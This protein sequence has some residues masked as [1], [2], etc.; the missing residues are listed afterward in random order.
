MKKVIIIGAGMGGLVAGN[1]L[2]KDGHAV[3]IFEAHRLPGGYTAGFYRDGFYFESG[4]LSFEAG[5]SVFKAMRDI[6]VYD[7]LEFVRK[8]HRWVT[9]DFDGVP[10]SYADLKQMLYTAYPTEKD[11]LDAFFA[12][13][14]KM[15]VVTKMDK[16]MPYLYHGLP[17]LLAMLSY[18]P[19]A[20]RAAGLLKKYEHMTTS[21]FAAQFFARGSKLYRLFTAPAYPDMTAYLLGGFLAGVFHDYWTVKGGMQSWAD[22]LAESF[23]RYGGT[24]KLGAPVDKIITRDGAAAG[25]A[26][27]GQEYTADTVI[28]ACDYKKTLLQMLDDK[29]LVPAALREKIVQAAVSEGVFTVYLGLDM[30]NAALRENMVLPDVLYLNANPDYDIYDANDA[31]F[32]RKTPLT[33]YSPS[34]VNPGHAPEGK[35]SL[36][37]QTFV[38]SKWMGN[39]G[40]GDRTV[41]E[42]LKETARE[43]MIAQAAAIIPGVADKIVYKD[44]AT[45]LTYERF[46]SNTD[47]ATSAWS[48]NPHR[49]FYDQTMSVNVTTPVKNLYIGSCWAMQIGGIPGALAAAYQC[50]QKV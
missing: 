50:A 39:W 5:A 45:P 49:K 19:G 10:A 32:F 30:S 14:D 46:T 48:W 42:R 34:L 41:Y 22:T 38:P 27:Q 9:A 4:T 2:A 20:I 12:E 33:I 47:G 15:A 31:A 21:E 44:A 29:S 6:G 16:P 35:A 26:C 23:K 25:V 24:L 40:G 28:A 37:L 3:T 8:K 18:I 17:L 11:S 43:E 7:Q 13:T 1:L 36:M